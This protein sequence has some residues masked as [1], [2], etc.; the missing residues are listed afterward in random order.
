MDKQR[1]AAYCRV[2]TALEVQQDSLKLQQEWFRYKYEAQADV[3]LVG[4]YTDERSGTRIDARPGFCAM[5][6]DCRA[7]KIDRIVTKSVSRFS[8]NMADFLTVIGELRQLQIPVYFEREG[9][10]SMDAHGEMLLSVLAAISQ[11]EVN[12]I[13]SALIWSIRRRDAAGRPKYRV[14]YGFRREGHGEEWLIHEKEASRVR[15]AF[16]LAAEGRTYAELEEALCAM[17][18]RDPTGANWNQR[19]LH[20]VLTNVHYIGAVL[21]QK[22][23]VPDYL[24]HR[25]VRNRGAVDQYYIRDHH[26]AIVDGDLFGEVNARIDAGLL[27]SNRRR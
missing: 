15:R 9:I 16:C 3:H 13:S 26:P 22:T 5:L 14:S 7:G 4:I 27:R 11:E 17:E 19:R 2:S 25:R 23:Y 18:R 20:Y 24:N 12:A 1:V 21:T 10:S 6:E 8:R